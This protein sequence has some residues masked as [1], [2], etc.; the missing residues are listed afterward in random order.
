ML[1]SGS[2]RRRP[3]LLQLCLSRAKD[4]SL[5]LP[6]HLM[7]RRSRYSASFGFFLPKAGRCHFS[8]SQ[9]RLHFPRPRYSN[10]RALRPLLGGFSL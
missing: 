2:S 4:R 8:R 9:A 10:I 6:W 3:R 7:K 1:Q 5:C